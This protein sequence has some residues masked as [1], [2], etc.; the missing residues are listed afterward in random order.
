MQAMGDKAENVA[1]HMMKSG[2]P[3]AARG[4]VLIGD[5]R[6]TFVVADADQEDVP[7]HCGIKLVQPSINMGNGWSFARVTST[8]AKD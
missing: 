5:M 6:T 3:N 2:Y 8:D 1:M 4:I 7:T